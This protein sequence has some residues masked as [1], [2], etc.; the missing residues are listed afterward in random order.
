[1]S[2]TRKRQT[3]GGGRSF[4]FAGEVGKEKKLS[5]CALNTWRDLRQA[6][7]VGAAD[8]SY[9]TSSELISD[10]PISINL[11]LVNPRTLM[12]EKLTDQNVKRFMGL[13]LAELSILK[14]GS[15]AKSC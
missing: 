13:E 10:E 8:Q 9:V 14:T 11:K 6:L 12:E 3:K 2:D 5:A 7:E 15:D 4:K 1:M